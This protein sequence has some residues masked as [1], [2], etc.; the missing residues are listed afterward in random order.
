VS[1]RLVALVVVG[2]GFWG[3]ARSV[4]AWCGEA[5]SRLSRCV[6]ESFRPVFLMLLGM[7]WDWGAV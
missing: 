1:G 2:G 7:L 5:E 6:V 3:V 4:V